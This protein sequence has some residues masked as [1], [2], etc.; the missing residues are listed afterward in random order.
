MISCVS[1]SSSAPSVP[2][3][4]GTDGA[5]L[6]A[7]THEIIHTGLYD[8][9]FLA[10]YTNAGYLINLDPQSEAHGLPVNDA[11]RHEDIPEYPRNRLWWN[12]L[13]DQPAP[14]HQPEADPY[15]LGEFRLADGTPVKPAFQLLLERV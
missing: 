2:G 5:L 15:L 1:A 6:L 12:R 13:N 14:C 8:R 4:I 7:L 11:S 9:E 3:L 10:R